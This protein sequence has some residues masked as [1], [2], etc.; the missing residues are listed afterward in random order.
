MPNTCHP[1]ARFH[2]CYNRV[3]SKGLKICPD[4]PRNIQGIPL[5]NGEFA[6]SYACADEIDNEPAFGVTRIKDIYETLYPNRY[7]PG[8]GQDHGHEV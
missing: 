8:I 4:C 6:C 1:G 5:S 3:C 2:A 7:G